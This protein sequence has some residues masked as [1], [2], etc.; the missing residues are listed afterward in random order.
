MSRSKLRVT[1]TL[2]S[3]FDWIERKED[4]FDDF[5]R[6][7]NRQPK[8]AS[9]AMLNGIEFEAMVNKALDGIPPDPEHKWAKNARQLARYLDG[10]QQQVTL[11]REVDV[12][13][14]TFL[15]HGVLDFL[16]AGVIYDTKF[17]KTYKLGK[18][19][20]SPQHPM[21]FALVP[22]AYEFQYLICDGNWVYGETYRPDI[23]EPIE[24]EIR[25]FVAFLK[26]YGLFDDY[27]N[28]W[29]VRP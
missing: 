12:D 6:T 21:Y 10:A 13:G 25:D 28:K 22:E 9:E 1:Q 7:L 17:S 24:G 18:Y 11:F 5:L 4:G 2:L 23:T 15:L 3:A 27:K 19:R 29:A 26:R 20:T 14:Q 8:E 16:R